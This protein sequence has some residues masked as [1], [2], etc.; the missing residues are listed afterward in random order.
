MQFIKRAR[1]KVKD[2]SAQALP[3]LASLHPSKG[4]EWE[5][6]WIMGCEDGH[7]PHVEAPLDVE[8]RLFYVGLTAPRIRCTSPTAWTTSPWRPGSLPSAK[9]RKALA[10]IGFHVV[11]LIR[12]TLNALYSPACADAP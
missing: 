5:R 11:I 6:V 3:V 10:L 1:N 2:T 7:V 8:R 12:H 4:L 9:N